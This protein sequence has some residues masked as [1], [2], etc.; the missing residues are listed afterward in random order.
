M[1]ARRVAEEVSQLLWQ[2]QEPDRDGYLP[3][4]SLPATQ[5]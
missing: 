3:I 5:Q 2:Q 4:L 1:Q